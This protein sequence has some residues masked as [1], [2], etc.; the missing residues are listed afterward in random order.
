MIILFSQLHVIEV[1]SFSLSLKN[2]M[3]KMWN[4]EAHIFS[5]FQ[6]FSEWHLN[7]WINYK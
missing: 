5:T 6:V 7:D 3:I 1:I 4:W 2:Y